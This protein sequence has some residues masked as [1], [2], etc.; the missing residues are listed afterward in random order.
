VHWADI[1]ILTVIGVSALFSLFRGLIREVLSLV[2]WL[3]AG[4]VAYQFAGPLGAQMAGVVSVPSVRMA[5]AFLGLL[6]GVL[7]VFGVLNFL[8]GKLIDSTGLS[9]TDRLLGVIFGVARGV[10]IITVLVML[11]GLTPVPRDPWWRDS[12]FLTRFEQL[13]RFAIAWLPPEFAKHFAYDAGA[14]KKL[15]DTSSP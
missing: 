7:I 4:W 2:G 12:M 9:A 1:F 13:A 15:R 3:E 5:L 11:A 14:L 6:I 8:I 10:A